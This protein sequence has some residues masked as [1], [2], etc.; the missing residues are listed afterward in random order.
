M[1]ARVNL[2]VVS[3][4]LKGRTFTFEEHETFIFGRSPECHAKLAPE[5]TTASR[6]HFILEVDPPDV[7]VRDL[8]SLNGTY[9]ND[10]KHGGR[11]RGSPVGDGAPPDGPGV[12][13]RHGDTVRVGQTVFRVEVESPAF[14]CDC[15][16]AIADNDRAACAWIAGTFICSACRAKAAA[17]AAPKKD[18][19]RCR[20]CRKDVARELG[21]RPTGDYVCDACRAK[22]NADPAAILRR[23]GR[24]EQK[25]MAM[26]EVR[27]I[28][29]YDLGKKLG[30]G[31]MGAVYR[32]RRLSDG[33]T[34]A[35]KVM[36]SKVAV[37]KRAREI[38]KRE[39]DVTQS[40]RHPH[41]VELY[42]HG[43]IGS[44]FFF[45]MELCSGGSVEAVMRER[46]GKLAPGDAGAI[47]LQALSG[48]AY[49]HEQGF[50]HRDL[51]PSNILLTGPEW[52]IAKVADFGLAKSFQNAG[53]SGMTATGSTAGTYS[54]MPREQLVNFK[55]TKPVSDVWSM[56]ASLYF[57]ITGKCPRDFPRGRDPIEII[58]R[59][60][61]IPVRKRRPELSASLAEVIDRAVADAAVDRFQSAS[62][63]KAALAKSL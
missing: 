58:L 6:H 45:V 4:P 53:L 17:G 19:P 31:G 23:I 14:C 2:T 57:M 5:D 9:V 15:N 50:V 13:L 28:A 46:G 22:H 62:D 24:P 43:S 44:A 30:Q 33:S 10:V 40:M 61:V 60:P 59:D 54:F 49:A 3:G 55:M 12:D 25:P 20:E 38:F 52:S 18:P 27:A 34:V 29:G 36:L 7:R 51:K 35:V 56:G 37:D 21:H 8:R 32:A 16:C 1:T 11:P 47:M 26:P 63:F 39:I 42:E 48:L 41:C